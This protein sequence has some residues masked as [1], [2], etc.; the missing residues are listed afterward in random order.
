MLIVPGAVP[1][2][3]PGYVVSLITTGAAEANVDAAKPAIRI[4]SFFIINYYLS[5]SVHHCYQRREE[6]T[7]RWLHSGARNVTSM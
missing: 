3:L 2:T 4:S 7:N 6:N 5:F 1:V